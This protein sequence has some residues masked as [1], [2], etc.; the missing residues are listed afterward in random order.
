M[1]SVRLYAKMV[2]SALLRTRAIVLKDG[3]VWI[4]Q[5]RYAKI[6]HVMGVNCVL[7]QK[8]APVYQGLRNQIM[9][10]L[11]LYVFKVAKMGES[12]LVQIHALVQTAGLILIVRHQFVSKLVEMAE[13]VQI[14]THARVLSNGRDSIVEHLSVLKRVKMEGGVLPPTHVNVQLDLPVMIVVNLFV[15]KD[16]SRLIL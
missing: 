14:Q 13:T 15:N 4:V 3:E 16:I 9:D 12:V 2:V 11:S 5:N 8:L 6:V 7:L 10:A 1:L